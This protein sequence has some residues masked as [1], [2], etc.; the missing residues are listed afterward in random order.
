MPSTKQK[1]IA[2]NRARPPQRQ[3]ASQVQQVEAQAE[4]PTT[5]ELTAQTKVRAAPSIRQTITTMVAAGRSNAEITDILKEQF[6]GTKAAEKASRHISFYRSHLNKARKAQGEA[7]LKA[8]RAPEAA[9]TPAVV[10]AKRGASQAAP[11]DGTAREKVAE[12]KA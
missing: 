5:P 3:Q 8:G 4:E 1:A 12:G 9:P 6:P 7:P 2:R 10:T 11:K